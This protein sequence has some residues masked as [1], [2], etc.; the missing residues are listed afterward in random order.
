MSD[1]D[2]TLDELKALPNMSVVLGEGDIAWQRGVDR[3]WYRAGDDKPLQWPFG[4]SRLIWSP[5]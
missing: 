2:L 1:Q 5:R 4:R 3:K